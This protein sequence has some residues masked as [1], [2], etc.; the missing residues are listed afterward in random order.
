MGAYEVKPVNVDGKAP[1]GPFSH[2]TVIGPWIHTIGT[3]GIDPKTQK[4]VS[5]D[6]VEQ[7]HQSL[8]N[9]TAILEACGATL[10]HVVK[11]TVY[12][13]DIDDYDRVNEVYLAAMAPNRPARC[14]VGV[15]SLTAQEKMKVEMV[16]YLSGAA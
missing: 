10:Q 6:V 15:A 13:T 9:L 5:D 7:T 1:N 14:C 8:R 12:L 3:G 11:A 16:A 2:A 4:I